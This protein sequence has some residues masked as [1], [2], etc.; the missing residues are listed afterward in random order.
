VEAGNGLP[1]GGYFIEKIHR[2]PGFPDMNFYSPCSQIG[3]DI[4]RDIHSPVI[5][6]PDNDHLW[7]GMHDAFKVIHMEGMA[8]FSPP[9]GVYG[10][11]ENDHVESIGFPFYC[12]A[13]EGVVLDLHA[14]PGVL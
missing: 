9:R 11:R 6:G 4:S 5:T 2:F 12:D 10:F 1:A 3:E 7:S 8:L 14:I 13:S